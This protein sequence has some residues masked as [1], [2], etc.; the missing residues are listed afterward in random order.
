MTY[1]GATIKL[2]AGWRIAAADPQTNTSADCWQPTVS[3]TG[4][5]PFPVNRESND[6]PE[7]ENGRQVWIMGFF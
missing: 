2:G 5:L 1:V 6:D 4:I 7:G 3:A